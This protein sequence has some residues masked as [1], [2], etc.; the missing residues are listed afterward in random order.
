VR[1]LYVATNVPYPRECGGTT[2]V[3]GVALELKH[4][5]HE[6]VICARA[7]PGLEEGVHEGIPVHRFDWRFR[8]IGLSKVYHRWRH[9]SRIAKLAKDLEV[10]L[11]YER[12]SSMGAGTL[13][14]R[15][16]D[17]PL[18]AEVNDLWY[19]PPMLERARRIIANSGGVKTLIPERHHHKTVFVHSAVDFVSFQGAEPVVIEGL[20]GRTLVGYTGSILAWH[21][22]EDLAFA[23]PRILEEEPA[24]TIIIA[25]EP[26]TPE[27]LQSL[28]LVKYMAHAAGQPC[29]VHHLGRV[30][31]SAIPGVLAASEVCVAP[32]NPTPEPALV[33]RG[34]W[35]SPMKLWEYLAAGRPVVATDLENIRDILAGGRGLLV[36]PNDPK[37]LAAGVIEL[38]QDEQRRAEMGELGRAFAR[39][40]SWER[41]VDDYERALTEAASGG[42]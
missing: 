24:V 39:N 40:N 25:G 14:S 18:A 26:D 7:G 29:A 35:Y 1:V 9:G 30:P 33:E 38:L 17:L 20:E 10:D 22:I 27:S 12:E 3:R 15:L 32:Y 2:H 19:Y 31:Y 5:G 6:V 13:A 23:L 16:T 37:A 4:R 8:D 41:R 21:G 42:S 36:P 28:Y 34:F 11:I